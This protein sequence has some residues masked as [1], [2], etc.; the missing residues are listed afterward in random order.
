MYYFEGRHILLQSS[1]AAFIPC[2]L[3]L[4]KAYWDFNCCSTSFAA[5]HSHHRCYYFLFSVYFVAYSF[6]YSQLSARPQDWD[7]L[8][9]SYKMYICIEVWKWCHW[10]LEYLYIIFFI[11]FDFCYSVLLVDSICT[12]MYHASWKQVQCMAQVAV[13]N[14]CFVIVIC[15]NV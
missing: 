7:F 4:Q 8:N 2:D 1:M 5:P 10:V 12:C 13:R 6:G 15:G 14:K 3:L 9:N 11:L